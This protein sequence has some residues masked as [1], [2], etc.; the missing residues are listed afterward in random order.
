MEQ[1]FVRRRV[2]CSLDADRGK[3][4]CQEFG[5]AE[6]TQDAEAMIARADLDIIDIC[7]P[8]SS[9]FELCRRARSR[10]ASM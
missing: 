5:I 6:Y 2:L 3:A 1:G 4:L 8:P 7:T 9:H 10:R